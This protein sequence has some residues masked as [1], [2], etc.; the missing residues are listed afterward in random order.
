MKEPTDGRGETTLRRHGH[1]RHDRPAERAVGWT[2][3][4]LRL[5][6]DGQKDQK[7]ECWLESHGSMVYGHK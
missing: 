4:V 1:F 5:Y 3:V 7:Q 6:R 2:P